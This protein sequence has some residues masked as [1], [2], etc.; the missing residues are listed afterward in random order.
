M[1][2]EHPELC[3]WGD[4]TAQTI[5][6]LSRQIP[7]GTVV[8]FHDNGEPTCYPNLGWALK[9]FTHCIRQFNTNGKLLVDK[10]P[11]IIGNLEVLTVSVIENDPEWDAQFDTVLE[12][13]KLKKFSP[14]MMVYRLLGNVLH[15]D[16]WEGLPGMIVSRVLHAPGGSYQYRKPVTKPEI[17][18]CLDLLTHLAVDRKGNISLCVRFDPSGDL[19]L[20]NI[21]NIT[22]EE[23]WNGDKRRLY[24]ERHVRGERELCPGCDRCDYYGIPRGE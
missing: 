15:R 13:L 14:P 3:D 11:E 22:L 8:Q 18:I 7:R 9:R 19:R 4:M 6:A 1:E 5:W 12:F 17:G 21:E 20:G 2:R 16:W 23:A 24:V 10:A